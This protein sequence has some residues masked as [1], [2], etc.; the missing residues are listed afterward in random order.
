MT[1]NAVRIIEYGYPQSIFH[2]NKL[3]NQKNKRHKILLK[4]AN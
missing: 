1:K 3:V 2:S 4:T